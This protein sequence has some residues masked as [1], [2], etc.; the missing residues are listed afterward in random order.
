VS[1]RAALETVLLVTAR[2]VDAAAAGAA[3]APVL[4]LDLPDA[5]RR[6]RYAA[7]IVAEA[8]APELAAALVLA[9]EAAGIGARRVAAGAVPRLARPRRALR[10]RAGE[11]GLAF[12]LGPLGPEI[13]LGWEEI[14]LAL[15]FA[16]G[17]QRK[18]ASATGAQDARAARAGGG[19]AGA[20]ERA[21]LFG[22]LS[23]EAARLA[24]AIAKEPAR[25]G[26][27]VVAGGAVYRVWRGEFAAEVEGGGSRHS[28]E[29]YLAF[30]RAV[31]ARALRAPEPP[32]CA[33][34]LGAGLVEPARFADEDEVARY[35]R[36][37]LAT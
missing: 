17:G 35:E 1:D 15:P 13:R 28:L 16:V 19:L 11:A 26:L 22:E 10:G 20:K 7:G 33:A 30:G 37:L 23:P 36:W 4:G 32:E 2:P 14:G 34:I 18:T 3:I 27:D 25:L 12:T 21:D 5:V 6:A 24:E 9:L 29:S 8:I 31:V